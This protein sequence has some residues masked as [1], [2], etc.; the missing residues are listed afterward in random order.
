MVKPTPQ[1]LQHSAWLSGTQCTG[2]RPMQQTPSIGVGNTST[3][4]ILVPRHVALRVGSRGQ[5]Q[6]RRSADERI[7]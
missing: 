5:L 1:L 4:N 3:E 6:A 7:Y 2:C